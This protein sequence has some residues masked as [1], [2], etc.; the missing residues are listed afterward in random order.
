MIFLTGRIQI[1]FLFQDFRGGWNYNLYQKHM[2]YYLFMK[3][4]MDMEFRF[5]T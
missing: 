3:K 1:L 2:I 5:Y 4:N